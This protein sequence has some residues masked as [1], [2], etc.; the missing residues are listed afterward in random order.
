MV[1]KTITVTENS[2][3]SI[4]RLKKET[5]SFSE[6]FIRLGGEHRSIRDIFG[7]LKHDAKEALEFKRRI[8]EIREDMGKAM[9][10]RNVR[11]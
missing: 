4:I 9:E 10:K 6:L 5:E 1:V 3:R 11:S 2:Y 8:K 7:I